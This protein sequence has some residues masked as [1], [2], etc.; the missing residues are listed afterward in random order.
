[1]RQV[2]SRLHALRDADDGALDEDGTFRFIET[3]S[4]QGAAGGFN[5]SGFAKWIVDGVYSSRSGRYLSITEVKQK[6]PSDRGNRWSARYED[7]R[8]P[9]FGLDWSRNLALAAAGR[10]SGDSEAA[11]VRRVPYLSYVEDVGYPVEALGL[12]VY[13]LAVREPGYF[14]LG[15][16]NQPFGSDPV[17]RQHVHVVVVFPYFDEAGRFHAIVMERNVE[18]SLNSLARRYPGDSVHL[19]RVPMP[20]SLSLPPVE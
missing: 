20:D 11:D 19:V 9:Y 3:L 2:R 14:Y 16:V 7:E 17:L 6:R 10:D 13:L 18:T 12:A 8:D 15:S 1:V 5:C 4:P